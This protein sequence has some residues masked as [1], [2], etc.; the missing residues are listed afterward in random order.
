[1]AVGHPGSRQRGICQMAVE[2]T[3]PGHAAAAGRTGQVP[4]AGAAQHRQCVTE[5]SRSVASV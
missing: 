4:S 3:E 1:M 5:V 2:L